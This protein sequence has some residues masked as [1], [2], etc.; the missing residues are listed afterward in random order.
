[1]KISTTHITLG[2]MVLTGIVMANN[3]YQLSTLGVSTSQSGTAEVNLLGSYEKPSGTPEI[4]GEE[5]GVS[6]DDVDPYDPVRANAVISKL[7]NLDRSI[8]LEG[9]DKE[10][11][12]NALYK[13]ENGIS[14]EYCCGA[15][16]IIFENGEPACGCAHS[17]AMRGL[18]K[19]LITEHGDEY[20]DAEILEEIGKWKALF[21]PNQISNKATILEENGLETD[22]VSLTS[23]KYRG[24]EKQVAGGSAGGMVGGC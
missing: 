21:F 16:S 5:L 7:G 12:I 4:Y 8:T 20:T 10:R 14:C 24:V 2:L 9:N 19:Y 13:L 17:Y 1:M 6:Y 15:R 11:Y 18:A 3:T 23:N 22:M